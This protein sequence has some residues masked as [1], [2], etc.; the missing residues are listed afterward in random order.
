MSS[1]LGLDYGAKRVGVAIAHRGVNIASPL[2]T[3][4]NSGSLIDD[5]VNIAAQEKARLFVVGLPRNLDGDDTEQTRVVR[6]FADSL[7]DAGFD[8]ALQDEAATTVVID[9]NDK[10]TVDARAAS[11][12]LSDYLTE[13]ERASNLQI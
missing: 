6:R 13:T 3:I 5:L 12:I 7:K 11:L 4:E 9:S 1:I 8:V 2:K 10:S